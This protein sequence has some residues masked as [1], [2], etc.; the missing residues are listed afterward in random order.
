MPEPQHINF[1]EDVLEI[2]RG[3][4]SKTGWSQRYVSNFLIRLLKDMEITIDVGLKTDIM[5]GKGKNPDIKF[6]RRLRM[7]IRPLSQ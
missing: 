4:S 6:K 5:P 7:K 2:L 1:D 3:I